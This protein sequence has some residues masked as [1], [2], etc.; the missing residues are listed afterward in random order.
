MHVTDREYAATAHGTTALDALATW[1]EGHYQAGDEPAMLRV[2]RREVCGTLSDMEIK[3][4]VY[5]ASEQACDAP[6]V[7]ARLRNADRC[8]T[9]S[10]PG[11]PA[12]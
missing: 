8:E 9:P 2:I 6:M 3:R 4:L 11:L 1:L 5:E 7:L 12:G 10:P